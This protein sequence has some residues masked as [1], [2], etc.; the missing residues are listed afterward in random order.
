MMKSWL[1]NFLQL[2]LI[3]G[4]VFGLVRTFPWVARLAEAAALGLR[5][6]WWL[7]LVLSLGSWT[8]WT[9]RQRNA[10]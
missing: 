2:A 6:F 3:F 4:V 7:V 10:G 1:R 9:L 8:I 5:E